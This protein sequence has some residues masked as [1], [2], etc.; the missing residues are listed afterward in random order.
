MINF[1]DYLKKKLIKKLETDKILIIDN[2][3]LH[4]KHKSFDSNKL[5]LKFIIESA[6]L[7]EMNNV[8]AERIIYSILRDELKNKIHSIQIEI[9]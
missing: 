4:Q 2:S 9:K 3:Y 5:H 7:K 8:D 1:L 6:K